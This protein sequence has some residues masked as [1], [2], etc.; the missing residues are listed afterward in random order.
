M[1][2]SLTQLIKIAPIALFMSQANAADYLTDSQRFAAQCQRL[3]SRV[4]NPHESLDL[5][6]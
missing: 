1:F 4:C 3:A 2:K 6:F 5:L